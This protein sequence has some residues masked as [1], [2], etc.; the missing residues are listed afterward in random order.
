MGLG[1]SDI[2][3]INIILS[4]LI[5]HKKSPSIITPNWIQY[6]IYFVFF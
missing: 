1:N 4:T 6:S 3:V 5:V 2:L